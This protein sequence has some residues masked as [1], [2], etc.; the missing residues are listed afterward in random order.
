MTIVNVILQGVLLGGLYALYAVGLSLIFGVMRIVN[1]AHGDLSIL[2]AFISLLIVDTIG[3]NPL[4]AL[5]AVIPLMFVVGYVLQLGILNF[6]LSSDEMRPI[7][8]TFGMSIILQNALL[9]TFT[10]DSQGLDAGP[11]ENASVTLTSNLAIGWF[12]LIIMVAA[13]VVIT[14]LNFFLT[15]TQLGRAFRATSDDQEA[16]RLMGVNNRRVYGLAM[17]I[18]LGIVALAG[19]VMGIRTTFDPLTGPLRL[20]FAYETVIIGGLGSSWGTLIGGVILG[21]AQA[22]GAYASPGWGILAGHLVFLAVLAFRPQ[23][24]LPKTAEI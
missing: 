3:L 20:I 19:V 4:L 2:A 18:S 5:V 21:V 15:R 1:L 17:G 9:E 22:L 7:L 14:G 6:T 8:V 24:L 10:A 11:V 23:G 13:V 16:A 12:P